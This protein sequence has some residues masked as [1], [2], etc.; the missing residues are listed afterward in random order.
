MGGGD[1]YGGGEGATPTAGGLAL[2]ART[3]E[4]Q[5][6]AAAAPPLQALQ[7]QKRDLMKVAFDRRRPEE[8][9][10]MRINDVRLLMDL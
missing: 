6:A 1:G 3:C 2:R 9:R 8:L 7:E 4:C 5:P 10:Q